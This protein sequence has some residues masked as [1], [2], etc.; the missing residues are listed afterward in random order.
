MEGCNAIGTPVCVAS[1]PR[2]INFQEMQTIGQPADFTVKK[3][4]IRRP[5][6]QSK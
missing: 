6:V 3:V 2:N 5:Q 4:R 1:S